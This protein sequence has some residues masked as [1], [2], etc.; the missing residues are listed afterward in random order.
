M[1]LV[2]TYA[3]ATNDTAARDEVDVSTLDDEEKADGFP[4][5]PTF[6]TETDDATSDDVNGATINGETDNLLLA[7]TFA[8]ETD[9]TAGSTE[10]NVTT[11]GEE[12]PVAYYWR[13]WKQMML[14]VAMKWTLLPSSLWI[15]HCRQYVDYVFYTHRIFA[16]VSF[17]QKNSVQQES[18]FDDV[19][20][21]TL[22][23]Y[24]KASPLAVDLKDIY[25]SYHSQLFSLFLYT[26]SLIVFLKDASEDGVP[27]LEVFRDFSVSLLKWIRVQSLGTDFFFFS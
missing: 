8:P 25:V 1:P 15:L 9:D 20:D 4:L 3:P 17:I 21:N 11:R 12:K 2:P 13:Q 22:V 16:H 23:I 7:P 18:S 19:G 6:T 24:G 27:L 26:G 5:A 10:V 14:T